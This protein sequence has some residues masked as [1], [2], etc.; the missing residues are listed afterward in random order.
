[1]KPYYEHAGVTLY[2]GDAREVLASLP[3]TRGRTCAGPEGDLVADAFVTDPPYGVGLKVRKTKH[4]VKEA[5]YASFEDTPENVRATVV[6]LVSALVALT[7]RGCLTPGRYCLRDYPPW[8]DLG[9]LYEGA[10]GGRTRWGFGCGNPLLYYG[11]CPYMARGMG[12]RPSGLNMGAGV[13]TIENGHPCPKPIELVKWMVERV[14][15]GG[16][17]VVDPFAGSGTTLRACKLL[18]RRA[19]GVEIEEAYCEIAARLLGQEVLW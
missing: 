5:K 16:E 9:W 12:G 19:I 8:D 11:R 1:M 2:H 17:T 14:S 6:P 4:T 15:L 18:G 7:T 13:R 10:G 3:T